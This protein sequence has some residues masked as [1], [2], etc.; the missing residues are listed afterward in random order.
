MNTNRDEGIDEAD[1]E[2]E[3]AAKKVKTEDDELSPTLCLTVSSPYP[4]TFILLRRH[5]IFK[6]QIQHQTRLPHNTAINSRN[7][8]KDYAR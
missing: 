6:K 4:V 5:T 7:C 1:C 2:I 3:P 8:N